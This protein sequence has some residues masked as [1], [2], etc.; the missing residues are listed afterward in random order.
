MIVQIQGRIQLNNAERQHLATLRPHKGHMW[1][2][3]PDDTVKGIKQ[4]IR[5]Q[6][7]IMQNEICAYCGLDLGGTS[8]GQI[9][10]IA[11][12]GRYGQFTFEIE[13]LAMACHNCN[14][15]GNKGTA[16]TILAI[17]QNYNQCV[18]KLVHPYYDNPDH[19]FE[20]TTINKNVLIQSET[21]EGIYSIDL[22]DLAS[23]KK[24]ELRGDKIIAKMVRKN[25]AV[26]QITDELIQ[27]I[28][29]Y[30]P[31]ASSSLPA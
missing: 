6:L 1:D 11:P 19:H 20:W 26:D 31:A 8:E 21:D 13:N 18:F 3:K 22:L 10:H 28:V 5:N 4:K 2:K 9:E 16:N 27:R 23:P 24:S 30:R 29:E 17:N 7:L 14:G 25:Y 15:F 12:K